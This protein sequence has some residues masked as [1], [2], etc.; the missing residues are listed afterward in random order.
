MYLRR[1]E[2]E[3]DSRNERKLKT[4]EEEE[5]KER[6]KTIQEIKGN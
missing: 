1:T 5:M 6:Q 3:N 2:E 4:F